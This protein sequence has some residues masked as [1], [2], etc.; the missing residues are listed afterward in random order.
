MH[1]VWNHSQSKGNTRLAM[2]FV[3][4]QVR[5]EACEARV[6]YPQFL[7][8]L[9][10]TSRGSVKAAVEAAQKAGELEIAE[11][12]SGRRAPLYRLPKAVGYRRPAVR[13]GL[14]SG[15]LRPEEPEVC[16]PD[17]G[18]QAVRS[19]PDSGPQS[20][21]D[22]SRS[23]PDSGPQKTRS[24]PDSGPPPHNYEVVEGGQRQQD[25][26]TVCQ[27]LIKALTEAGITVSWGMPAD[28]LK[29]TADAVQRAG[30]PAMV[31]FAVDT[32]RSRRE[33]I[34]YAKFF[35]RGWSGLPPASSTPPPVPGQRPGVK[36]PHC[37]HPD[38]DPVTRT[39]EIEDDRGIRSLHPCPECHPN[40]NRKGH[41]A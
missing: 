27:P 34:L 41:A 5:T 4:D 33:R 29:R 22:D 31:R 24:G 12:A 38:C 15:P 35:A 1:W 37:R 16:G 36:P 14:D 9:G 20:S 18:P 10:V 6:S 39:R 21:A 28:D 13:S 8:A 2:L 25:P 7:Q 30:V 26:F 19:G 23:G 17:S 40:A 11:A 32:Q 3:A